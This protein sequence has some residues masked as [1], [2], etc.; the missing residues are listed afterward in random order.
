GV[1]RLFLSSLT[2]TTIGQ[3]TG[4]LPVSKRKRDLSMEAG[5]SIEPVYP[6]DLVK[7][8]ALNIKDLLNSKRHALLRIVEHLEDAT[9]T[10]LWSDYL[11]L[12][13]SHPLLMKDLDPNNSSHE[14]T[15]DDR[16]GVPVRYNI[17][18]IHVPLEVYEGCKFY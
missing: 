2:Q 11:R 4:F 12:N 3:T 6:Q 8:M 1:R 17:S 16:L 18:G 9:T 15:L 7:K 13:T 14:M 10:Y 5:V